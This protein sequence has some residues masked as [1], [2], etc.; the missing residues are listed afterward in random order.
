ML[1]ATTFAGD[2]EGDGAGADPGPSVRPPDLAP[3]E[4]RGSDRDVLAGWDVDADVAE[5][6]AWQ[7]DRAPFPTD[8]VVVVAAKAVGAAVGVAIDRRPV[9]GFVLG[10]GAGLAAAVVARRL[11]RLEP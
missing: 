7:V 5:L 3:D 2:G 4:V 9:R 10:A 6:T 1:D 11:W 8:L